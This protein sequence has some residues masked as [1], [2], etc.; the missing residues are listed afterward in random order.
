MG[1][2]GRITRATATIV[3]ATVAVAGGLVPAANAAQPDPSDVVIVLDYSASIMIDATTRTQFA[4][5]LDKIADRVDQTSA[6]LT[7]SDATVSMVQFATKAQDYPGCVDLSLLDN[8]ANVTKFADC[9]HSLAAAYR[10]GLDP[11]LTAKIGIDTNYVA[12][13]QQ[14]A[15][16][17]PTD[18]VRPVMILFTD[19][20]HDVKGVPASQIPIVK[21]QL[22]GNRSP[23]ALLPVGMG[24][25]PKDRP[26]LEQGLNDLKITKDM[27]ACLTGTSLTWP[28]VGFNTPDAAGTAV[29]TALQDATCTFTV[30][31]TPAPTPPPIPPS[32]RAIRATA[33]D[34]HIDLA[35]APPATS[36]TPVVSYKSRCRP[37][38]G[39]DNVDAPDSATTQLQ[40]TVD[41]LT[42]GTEY[43]CEVASVG[44]S[45]QGPW[46][47]ALSTATPIGKP[48]APPQPVLQA[49]NGALQV[50]ITPSDP[51]GVTEYHVDCSSDNGTNWT[52]SIDVPAAS[53]PPVATVQSLVNGTEYVCRTFAKNAVGQSDASITS[54]AAKPCA[55]FL[56][57][58]GLLLP[59][60]GI[61]GT[62]LALGL[63]AVAI[64]LF[65]EGRRGYVLAVVDVVHTANLGG[66]NRLGVSFLRAPDSKVV[67]GIV[68]D[69]GPNADIKIRLLPGGRFS[70][71]DG[72]GRHVTSSGERLIAVVGGV[73]HEIVL[74]AFETNAASQVSTRR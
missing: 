53:G 67:T 22:F 38:S 52:S 18:A 54:A 70:V 68:A 3:L 13:M 56:D 61:L 42:N 28:T 27:P 72:A 36:P 37:A 55:S 43:T 26:A 32:P 71:R 48:A 29:A 66:G 19:G 73:R 33:G 50:E 30:A 23:F 15:K 20:K 21:D 49:L 7:S 62:I 24:L 12:A 16:H 51:P 17:L 5:A 14:A 34:G 4:T 6:D 8:P 1:R 40:S 46:T 59:V 25:D 60:V 31:P 65:R 35:W 9:L 39:G 11:A 41:G 74:H 64:A 58:N 63:L 47:Q 10:K 44:A 69:K 45:S 2:L 57:C